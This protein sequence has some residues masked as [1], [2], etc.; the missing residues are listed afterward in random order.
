MA[1]VGRSTAAL[2][3]LALAALLGGGARAQPLVDGGSIISTVAGT[4]VVGFSGDGGP[5]TSASLNIPYGVAVDGGGNVFIADE[6][7]HRIRRVA[8]G[9]GVITTVAGTGTP[10]FSGDGGPGT[11]A[12][13]NRPTGVALDG[14]GNMLIAD[15]ENK[16]IR[17]LAAGTGVITTVVGNGVQGF[18]GDGGPGTSASLVYPSE[19]AVDGGGNM[20]IA[21][22]GNHRIRRLAA[23][24]GVISTVAGNGVQGFSGDG[25][26]GTSASLA[27]P[28][29]VAVD[30]GGNVLIADH[31][32][33]RIRRLA[34]GTGV[35]TTVAGTGVPGFSGDGGP[36]TSAS[37]VYPTGVAVDGGGNVLIADRANNRIR[38]LAAGTG[39]ISTV[40]GNG[41]QGFSGDGGPGTSASFNNPLAVAVDSG[42]NV[43][44]ADYLNHRI[45]RLAAGTGVTA[46]GTRSSSASPTETSTGTPSGS[47][48]TLTATPTPH[49]AASLFRPLP[50]TDLVGALVGSA[51]LAP[52]AAITLSSEAAC[53]EACCL[54]PACDGYTFNAENARQFGSGGCFL[55]VN[56][57]QLVPN[58]GYA[59]GLRESVLL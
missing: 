16:R 5:G 51:A 56:V 44:I 31:Y 57:T 43:L 7:N 10:G 24:T 35:I 47:T 30:G 42:G 33:H 48:A 23:G 1:R 28:R 17:R 3:L 53:R 29:G 25:G 40:A 58:N 38:R 34:A 36:G 49:C 20:L 22:P 37:L 32:N 13:L 21:D 2:R 14:G 55:L 19:V 6:S 9:T 52:G 27:Y 41:V 4:G 45:R 54:A 11:N 8:A 39:V 15:G 12:R 46:T 50:R 26:P 18:S 59:S